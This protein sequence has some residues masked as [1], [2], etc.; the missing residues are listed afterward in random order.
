M[1]RNCIT[2]PD[3]ILSSSA[4]GIVPFPGDDFQVLIKAIYNGEV[5]CIEKLLKVSHI[6]SNGIVYS[7]SGS[8]FHLLQATYI[9]QQLDIVKLLFTDYSMDPYVMSMSDIKSFPYMEYVFAIAPQSFIIS[10]MKECGVKTDYTINGG[11][12]LHI[13]VKF[14]CF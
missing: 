3:I 9:A 13:A 6:S 7:E 4:T 2:A 14:N 5:A 12:L 11:S 8:S 1:Y 10:I